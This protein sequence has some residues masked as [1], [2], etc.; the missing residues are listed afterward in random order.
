M[1]FLNFFYFSASFFALLD[2]DTDSESRS[3]ST[4]PIESGSESDPDP[5]PWCK[6]TDTVVI[7]DKYFLSEP[8]A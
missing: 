3:G 6:H 7:L 5:Q 1:K 4:D 8:I 2:L